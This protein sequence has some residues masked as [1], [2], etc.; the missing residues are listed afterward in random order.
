MALARFRK[1][2]IDAVEPRLLA[3]FWGEALR[4]RVETD[5]KREA[6]LVNADDKYTIWFNKVAQP[7][8][9][10]NRVHL[11]VY[12]ATLAD[13]EALGAK[14]LV[15]QAD[16]VRW[17]VMADP[18]GGEF[19]AFLRDDLPANRLHGL[20]VDCTNP[21]A[22]AKWW[23]KVLK[24]EVVH[25]DDYSTVQDIK[26]FKGVTLDFVPVPEH[27]TEPNRVHWDVSAKSVDAIVDAGATVLRSAD[28]VRRWTVLADPEGNEFCAFPKN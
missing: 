16:D 9:V 18:E 27:K 2:C 25:H 4:Q 10:K 24:A 6:G 22:Q 26:K 28:D 20:V 13:L 8:A 7:K 17:T 3:E 12:T 1:I 23:G 15:P 21:T 14:V 11:D 19:C 5:D